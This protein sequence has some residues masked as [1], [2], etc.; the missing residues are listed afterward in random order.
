MTLAEAKRNL[1]MM[2]II[3]THKDGEYR[4][5]F[6]GGPETCAYYTNDLTDA[7]QTGQQMGGMGRTF[8]QTKFVNGKRV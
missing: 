7:Y 6:R 2:N 4:I 1:S 3:L 8:A 5:N